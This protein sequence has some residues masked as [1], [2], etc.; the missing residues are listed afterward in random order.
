MDGDGDDMRIPRTAP[1]CLPAE[2]RDLLLAAQGVGR[3]RALQQ[4]MAGGD[5]VG[6]QTPLQRAQQTLHSYEQPA[7]PRYVPGLHPP[8][9]LD[10]MAAAADATRSVPTELLEGFIDGSKNPV[11]AVMEYC[12]IIGVPPVFSEVSVKVPGITFRFGSQCQIGDAVYPQ[13]SGKTKKEAKSNAAQV[14][15]NMILGL[16][17]DGEGVGALA[18]ASERVAL[19]VSPS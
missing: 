4:R 1:R 6:A 13:G 15:F 10:E 17:K 7:A 8:P 18:A 19:A 16:Q 3:G 11:S 12:S 2:H 5:G 9:S 14:A